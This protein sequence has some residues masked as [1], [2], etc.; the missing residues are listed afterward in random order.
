MAQPLAVVAPPPVPRPVYPS[1][2][3]TQDKVPILGLDEP[4]SGNRRLGLTI[5]AVVVLLAAALFVSTRGNGSEVVQATPAP[6]PAPAPRAGQAA[7]R[8]FVA[9]RLL[10]CR[11]SPELRSR[12]LRVLPR[13][14]AV[15]V[16][17]REPGWASVASDGRQCWVVDR[18]ISDEAPW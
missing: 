6:A 7:E 3:P 14:E 2:A 16:L 5:G 12:S 10:N 17:G 18:Y 15:Q 9:V 8:A 11:A 1:A 4:S 13:G